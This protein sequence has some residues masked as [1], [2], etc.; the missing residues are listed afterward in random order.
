[1]GRSASVLWCSKCNRLNPCR[2]IKGMSADLFDGEYGNHFS[3]PGHDDLQFF[4]RIRRCEKCGSEFETAELEQK[5]LSEL[6][7]LRNALSG[8]HLSRTDL[9][10]IAKWLATVQKEWTT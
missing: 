1:M 9:T 10:V 6:I 5:F 7:S 2:S 3:M 8:A 4:R